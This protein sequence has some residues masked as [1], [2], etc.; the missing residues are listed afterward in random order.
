MPMLPEDRQFS[1]CKNKV[2]E[3]RCK[4]TEWEAL[5]AREKTN[6]PFSIEEV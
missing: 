2:L 3:T 1:K 4:L 6:Y 5:E